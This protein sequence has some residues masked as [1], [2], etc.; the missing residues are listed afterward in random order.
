LALAFNSSDS[1]GETTVT[2]AET[3]VLYTLSTLAQTCAA[4]TAFV[5]AVG[6]YRAQSLRDE[7]TRNE[8]TLRGLLAVAIGGPETAS[9]QTIEEIVRLTRLN[10]IERS[11]APVA[12]VASMRRALAEWETYPA[13]RE[14]AIRALFAFETWNLLV[15]FAAIVGFN[16][17]SALAACQWTLPALWP[18]AAGTVAVTAYAVVVWTKG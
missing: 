12:V 7:H 17:V 16:H 4:L 15:I 10:A 18:V 5:G 3:T 9:R 2:D 13:R 1:F 6:L 14:S 8:T 11:S